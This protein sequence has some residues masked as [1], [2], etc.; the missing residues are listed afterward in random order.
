VREEPH[1]DRILSPGS[2]KSYNFGYESCYV[3]SEKK[4]TN[5][6]ECFENL[7]QKYEDIKQNFSDGSKV[8]GRFTKYVLDL[9]LLNNPMAFSDA[10]PPKVRYYISNVLFGD[11]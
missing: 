11:F 7:K 10:F 2:R 4:N 1:L 9:K 5:N 6:E 3:D 8:F